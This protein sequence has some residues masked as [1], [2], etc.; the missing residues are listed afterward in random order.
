VTCFVGM[1]VLMSVSG[2]GVVRVETPFCHRSSGAHS[3]GAAWHER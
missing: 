2:G 3:V 1:P